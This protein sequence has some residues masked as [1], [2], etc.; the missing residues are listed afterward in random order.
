ML[1][2]H[3]IQSFWKQYH[4][5]SLFCAML[6]IQLFVYESIQ[7]LFI[8]SIGVFLYSLQF[9]SSE[10]NRNW[11]LYTGIFL[12]ILYMLLHVQSILLLGF[13]CMLLYIINRL[14]G[15]TNALPLFVALV[16]LPVS[17]T[18]LNLISFDLRLATTK[19]V[20]HTL[21]WIIPTIHSEGNIIYYNNHTFGVDD[22]CSGIVML[23][24]GLLIA[25]L[26]IAYVERKLQK[27]ASIP[28]L[29][30][31]LMIASVSIVISNG[32]RIMTIVLFQLPESNVLHEIIGIVSLVVYF[33]LPFLMLLNWYGKKFK[34]KRISAVHVKPK[35][36]Q[37]HTLILSTTIVVVLA[38][39]YFLH[40][41]K[42]IVQQYKAIEGYQLKQYQ[43]GVA[44]YSNEHTLL[45]IKPEVPFYAANHHPR[46]CWKGSGYLFTNE[47]VT[48]IHGHEIITAMLKN[49][50]GDILYSAY[51]FQHNEQIISNELAWRWQAMLHGT[52]FKMINITTASESQLNVEV[53]KWL[54]QHT[55]KQAKQKAFN[56]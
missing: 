34:T 52:S 46:L 3:R 26:L 1:T 48:Q 42:D 53:S 2:T 41:K 25:L 10:V 54:N 45:Y 22:V 40:Q 51:W 31:L 32:F 13:I 9:E 44:Q 23:H 56:L 35:S 55:S 39:F 11:L 21:Q 16:S 8:F 37:N 14:F 4:T 6:L 29:I 18:V 17:S 27:F 36:R 24:I 30:G 33:A 49:E 5:L 47:K 12:Y 19:Y 43:Y 20:T 28:Q 38:S 50:Q 15:G 7:P